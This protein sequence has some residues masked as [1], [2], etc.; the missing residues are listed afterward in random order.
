MGECVF[1]SKPNCSRELIGLTITTMDYDVIVV[2]AGPGG[3]T[4]G[5]FLA[6]GGRKTL[7][8]EKAR[9][10]RYK[11][12]G[13]GLSAHML[14]A[15]FPFSFE[16]VIECAAGW[17]TFAMG[18]EAVR[19]AV[20][21]HAV[22]T[23]MREQF[24]AFLLERVKE[25]GAWVRTG[26]AVRRV[27]EEPE[28]V[29][30]ALTDG[31]KLRAPYVIG[32]DGA[33]SVVAR[34]AGLR[35]G[36]AMAAALEAEVP[37]DSETLRRLGPD[38][39]FIFGDVRAGYAWIF[40]KARSL[41]VGIMALRPGPGALQAGLQQVARRYGV[42]LEGVTVHGHPIPLQL[43]PERMMTR[44]VLLVGD[45]AG[46]ADPLSG[47]GIRLAIT[48]GKLAAEALLAGRPE[49][50]PGQ[51]WRK[52]GW[53]QLLA[54]VYSRMYAHFPRLMFALAGSNPRLMPALM[55]I[56]EGRGSYARVGWVA[57]ASLPM[58]MVRRAMRSLK[59]GD[60][61][62]PPAFAGGRRTT[63][64]RAGRRTKDPFGG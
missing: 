8:L 26:A 46:L 34:E 14:E 59:G 36:K 18:Q 17:V 1:D 28:G 13:G 45:A 23:V 6:E 60:D 4:A 49:Q 58:H 38:L 51:V 27:E 44:R 48:S 24:D 64:D 40:P 5:Y 3:A 37:A 47:E 61:R 15:V 22:R 35:R 32:A 7:V 55:E 42:S 56:L 20:P 57:G 19:V 62:R 10:P 31:T 41:S 53:S 43:R 25:A 39:Y 2:G 30:V 9:P 52:L 11:A 50:Y 54:G 29:V 21:G 63:D 16:P 12:C 33:N